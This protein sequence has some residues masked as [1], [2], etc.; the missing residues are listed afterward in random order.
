MNEAKRINTTSNKTYKTSEPSNTEKRKSLKTL[1]TS[2]VFGSAGMAIWHK[3]I[4]N[5][6]LLPAHAQT[7]N[8]A[9]NIAASSLDADN[10]FSRFVLIVDSSDTV[11]ANCG[12]SGG[13]A[14]ANN[15]AAGTYRVFA[16]SDG[17]QSQQITVNAGMSSIVITVPTNTGSCNFLVATVELPSGIIT[18]ANG[19]QVVGSWS[20]SSNQNTGCN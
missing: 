8:M 19:E 18:P 20:C 15:L 17:A 6:V 12:A 10:P 7:S 14:S 2:L 11:L 4:I 9:T 1:S 3:P 16:D 5:S 13:T